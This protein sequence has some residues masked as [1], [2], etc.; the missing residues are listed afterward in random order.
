MDAPV[1]KWFSTASTASTNDLLRAGAPGDPGVSN[2]W[3]WGDQRVKRGTAEFLGN[4]VGHQQ[5]EH[6]MTQSQHSHDSAGWPYAR[7]SSHVRNSKERIK[8]RKWSTWRFPTQ[9]RKCLENRRPCKVSTPL[10][11]EKGSLPM[12][13]M[14]T[15]NNQQFWNHLHHV[16]VESRYTSGNQSHRNSVILSMIM[17]DDTGGKLYACDLFS[18]EKCRDGDESMEPV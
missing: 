4:D 14:I 16:G 18:P 12:D 1:Q 17:D 3:S 6:H 2:R 10:K 7:L 13:N 5:V 9:R 11:G 8:E 15:S